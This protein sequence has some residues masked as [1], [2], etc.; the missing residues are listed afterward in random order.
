MLSLNEAIN[1]LGS[2]KGRNNMPTVE[3]NL[4]IAESQECIDAFIKLL[5]SLVV[6]DAFTVSLDINLIR[7]LP[8]II[9]S[10]YVNVDPGLHVLYYNALAYGIQLVR[11]AQDPLTQAAYRKIMEAIPAWLESSTES[12]IDGA[13]AALTAWAA[14]NNH[15]YQL[16]WK[17]HCKSCHYMKLHG[18]DQLDTVPAK[19]LEQEDK[20]DSSRYLYWQILATDLLFRLLLGKP[21]A[22]SRPSFTF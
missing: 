2:L 16:S 21:S 14:I 7:T 4:S 15:D 19:T 10:P 17:F 11:G 18:I 5:S 20:R 22:V 6:P 9:N 13:T 3:F 1:D 12:D 8:S